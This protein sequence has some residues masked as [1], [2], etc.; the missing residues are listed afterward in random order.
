M[1]QLHRSFNVSRIVSFAHVLKKFG[2]SHEFIAFDSNSHEWCKISHLDTL[3][4]LVW[5][6]QPPKCNPWYNLWAICFLTEKF[7]NNH[8]SHKDLVKSMECIWN[9]KCHSCQNSLLQIWGVSFGPSKIPCLWDDD[10]R[11]VVN[12][13]RRLN[14]FCILICDFKMPKMPHLET[15]HVRSMGNLMNKINSPMPSVQKM[16]L[17]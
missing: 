9:Y 6:K 13:P 8:G 11:K 7:V 2:L 5:Q 14:I 16:S 17:H 10:H 3:H 4:F 15:S 12:I 1:N